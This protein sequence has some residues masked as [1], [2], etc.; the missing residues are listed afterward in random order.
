MTIRVLLADDQPAIREAFRLLLENEPDLVVVAEAASG[1]S[2][3]SQ[4][5]RLRPDVC[6]V[7]VRMPRGDGLEVV[8]RLCG[9]DVEHP[10]PVVVVTT[11]D[12]DRYVHEAL[13]HGASGF[14]LKRSAPALLV[15]G[16]RAAVAGEQLI[17][18]QTT[19][20]LL[21]HLVAPDTGSDPWAELTD[22]EVEVA[23]LVGAGGSNAEIAAT[24]VVSPATVK[25]H[26][27]SIQRKLGVRNRVH[28]ALAAW[29]NN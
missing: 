12:L 23:R 3:I 27:A 1:E 7:D 24:L 29:R 18:P 14:L 4:A 20:R 28:V 8:R 22:R 5:E 21:R 10:I 11:F 9:H 13:A 16:V 2:A 6:L 25:N 17:N 15:E 26:L 19:V